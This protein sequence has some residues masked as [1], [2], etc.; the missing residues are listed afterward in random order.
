MSTMTLH[1]EG[2]LR[3]AARHDASGARLITDAPTDNHGKGESF[4]PTDLVCTALGSCMLTLMGIAAER[5]QLDLRGLHVTIT[6]HMAAS[7]RRIGQIDLTFTF[8]DIALTTA[9]RKLLEQTARRCPV[10]QSISLDIVQNLTFG[11][12]ASADVQP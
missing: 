11:W 4:S 1:Y 8:P 5:E 3:T 7:P 9:Q 2:A 10:A 12:P 6:K